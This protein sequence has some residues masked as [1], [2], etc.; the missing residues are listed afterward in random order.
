M[1]Q[2]PGAV[3]GLAVTAPPGD[4]LRGRRV[5]LTGHTG[6]KGSWLTLWLSRLGASVTGYALAPPTQPSHFEAARIDE[7]LTVHHESDVRDAEALL[8]AMRECRPDVIIHMAA[9]SLVPQSYRAPQETFDVN[10]G[11]TVRLLEAVRRIGRPCVVIV[12]TSDKCYE[13][14]DQH[15]GYVETDRLGGH[16]PYSASKAAAEIVVASYR[17]SFFDV[18]K[19]RAHGVKL[20]SVRAGNVFGGGDWAMDRIVPD[21]MDGLMHGRTIRIRNPDAVRPW[22]HVLEPLSGYLTLAARML[23]S[24]DPTWCD[25]WNF[26]PPDST[27]GESRTVRELVERLIRLWGDGHWEPVRAGD[28]PHE[29]QTLRLNIDKA[30]NVLGWRPRWDIDCAL[31]HVVQWYRSYQSGPVTAMRRTSLEQIAAYEATVAGPD[32]RCADSGPALPGHPSVR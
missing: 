27:H 23:G 21:A 28:A 12:V 7:L 10:V 16:D 4:A 13:N 22:Q 9:Q 1:E 20:A 32:I 14:R 31:E 29:T 11:G 3:E 15:A 26:G 24:D 25:A 18:A 6:F 17:R 19:I 5:F 30:V 8:E 2:R